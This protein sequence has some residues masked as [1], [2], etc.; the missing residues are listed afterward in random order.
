MSQTTPPPSPLINHH[1]HTNHPQ[2]T[3]M[4]SKD[5]MPDTHSVITPAIMYWG[6]PTV[7]ITTI[8]EH[9][10]ANI[11]PMSSAWWLGHRC[12]LGL[13]AVSQTTINLLRTGQCVLNLASD[14]MGPHINRIAKTTGTPEAPAL[15]QGLGYT[16]CGDKFA[17]AG[18]TSRPSD[19]VAPPRINEC[20]VQLEAQLV[21]HMALM[22]DLP[23]RS[24]AILAIE[25]K[26]LR[27]HIRH[28]LRMAGHANRVDPDRWRPLIMK[29]QEFYGLSGKKRGKSELAD[30]TPEER[31]RALMRSD[32]VKQGGDMDEGSSSPKK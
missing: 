15:K 21:N 20:P 4:G 29:F 19:L 28:D 24:G 31:Y 5:T 13:A 10:I 23:D 8:N 7:L 3:T 18:L 12:V 1:Y 27:T 9:G 17:L 14:D 22:Q 16:Y 6:T 32:V 25:V 2:S 26:I 11:G 30:S